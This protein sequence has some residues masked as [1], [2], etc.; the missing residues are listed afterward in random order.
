[1][2]SSRH[3]GS[4]G[5]VSDVD[6]GAMGAQLGYPRQ[7]SSIG[8]PTQSRWASIGR[9]AQLFL[10]PPRAS[11][12]DH[13]M[14]GQRLGHGRAGEPQGRGR[15]GPSHN[16]GQATAPRAAGRAADA[17]TSVLARATPHPP[18]CSPAHD[19][20]SGD[21]PAPRDGPLGTDCGAADR[22]SAS[23][24][25]A[26]RLSVVRASTPARTVASSSETV[27]SNLVASPIR[28]SSAAR[29]TANTPVCS[30]GDQDPQVLR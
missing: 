10:P 2:V 7:T 20:G 16:W 19:A 13:S 25:K 23:S 6:G 5:V 12:V 30:A 24:T 18:S 28:R 29:P 1:M 26:N 15:L 4:L 9:P 11:S 8:R 17:D 22:P 27:T 14:R 3:E 21:L